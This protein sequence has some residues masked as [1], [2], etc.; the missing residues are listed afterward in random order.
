MHHR[1]LH[2]H[3]GGRVQAGILEQGRIVIIEPVNELLTETLSR[4]RRKGRKVA[5]VPRTERGSAV[6]AILKA[7]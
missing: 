1:I 6:M 4:R 7:L 2:G 5:Q 3:K